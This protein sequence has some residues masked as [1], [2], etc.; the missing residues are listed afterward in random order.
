[1]LISVAML[2]VAPPRAGAA[3]VFIRGC[4]RSRR[5]R[6]RI[7]ANGAVAG[8]ELVRL[9][10]VEDAQNLLGIAADVEVVDGDVLD[11]VVRVD[12]ERR[13]Q[14]HALLRIAHAQLV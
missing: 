10:T 8:A 4:G 3:A 5:E 11:D 1:M 6:E 12:D 13:T 7:A 14:C 2:P 9:Q